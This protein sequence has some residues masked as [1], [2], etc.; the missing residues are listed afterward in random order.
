MISINAENMK[1]SVIVLFFLH[2]RMKIINKGD[3]KIYKLVNNRFMTP[4]YHSECVNSVII[5]EMSVMLL[6]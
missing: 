3:Q 4:T 2:K 6:A 5:K 1:A